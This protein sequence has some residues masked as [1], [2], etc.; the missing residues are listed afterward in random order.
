M[1]FSLF[2]L[3]QVSV[4]YSWPL[5]QISG[6][7]GNTVFNLNCIVIIVHVSMA[8]ESLYE[9]FH[10]SC[11][12]SVTAMKLYG[13]TD[14]KEL[15]ISVQV[16]QCMTTWSKV[17]HSSSQKSVQIYLYPQSRQMNA[18]VGCNVDILGLRSTSWKLSW[19]D[20]NIL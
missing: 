17:V 12:W 4:H 2:F 1:Q 11:Y 10:M 13:G 8:E 3:F 19:L 20:R 5:L 16:L 9:L 18:S 6:H 7:R 15:L 14:E